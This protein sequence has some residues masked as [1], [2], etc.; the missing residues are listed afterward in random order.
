MI[1]LLLQLKTGLARLDNK[2]P[3]LAEMRIRVFLFPFQECDKIHNTFYSKRLLITICPKYPKII[4]PRPERRIVL[5]IPPVNAGTAKTTTPI[6]STITPKFLINS[7]MVIDVF[8]NSFS[9]LLQI[10][11]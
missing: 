11:Q 6:R 1:C 4:K 2:N 3:G 10:K 5:D 9:F 7:L 8:Y